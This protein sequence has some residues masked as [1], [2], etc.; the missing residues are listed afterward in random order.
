MRSDSPNPNH[1]SLRLVLFPCTT[2]ERTTSW[3]KI[4]RRSNKIR[5]RRQTLAHRDAPKSL[6]KFWEK[7]FLALGEEIVVSVGRR[8][9]G[10]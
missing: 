3:L 2:N 7:S 6:I 5:Q 9:K 8:K 10:G 1:E 4:A